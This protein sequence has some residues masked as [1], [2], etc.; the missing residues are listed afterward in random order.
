[1]TRFL[2]AGAWLLVLCCTC[3]VA[4]RAQSAEKKSAWKPLMDGK[5]LTG[6]HK[7]GDGE[8]TVENGAFVGRA[9]KTK[10]YGLLVSD[11]VF[12]DLSVRFK[13]KVL[14]GDSGFYIRTIFKDPDQ[15]HGLQIQVGLAGS[16]CGGIY[17]S[18][19]R[20]WVVKPTE[21]QEK[22]ILRTDDWN[23]MTIDAHGGKIVVHVNGVKTADVAND[24]SRAEGHF[25]MQMHSGNVMHVMFKEI[26]ILEE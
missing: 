3:L 10:L 11:K 7:I 21:D 8:W 4:S 15:A 18:Y 23:D 19:G 22:K 1:M 5:T 17:E 9:N 13:F 26:E 24:P 25:A 20:A 12:K 14:T 16:G 2:R 6:W